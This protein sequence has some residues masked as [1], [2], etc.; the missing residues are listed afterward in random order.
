LFQIFVAILKEALWFG[1]RKKQRLKE[2]DFKALARL[3]VTG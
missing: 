3:D 2:D 1:L